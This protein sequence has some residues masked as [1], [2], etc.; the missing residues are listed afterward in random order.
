MAASDRRL[1][2]RYDRI[3][4]QLAEL[5]AYIEDPIARMATIA[6]IVH[7]KMP[8]YFWTGFY[9]LLDGK[10][11]VGP[12]QG[13]L[14][15]AVLDG[16]EGVCWA[17][18]QRAQPV[19]VPDVHAFPGHVACDSRSQSEVVVPVR[20]GSGAIVAVLDVDSDRLD[21]FSQT[22]VDALTAIVALVYA[23]A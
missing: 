4:E 9:R 1:A 14:A 8:H 21:A 17:G 13:P 22:D 12:Y 23:A 10:L 7:H 16:P 11:V 6:A 19:L 2:A 20:D 18:V 5:F 15:C 3:R